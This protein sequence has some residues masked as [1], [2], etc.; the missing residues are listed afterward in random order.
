MSAPAD[1][2]AD[3]DGV[4][5]TAGKA[6]A[7]VH[8]PS[9]SATCSAVRVCE[10]LGALTVAELLVNVWP[11]LVPSQ[12]VAKRTV[13]HGLVCVASHPEAA[14]SWRE[15]VPAGERVVLRPLGAQTVVSV[16]DAAALGAVPVLWESDAWLCV[17]KP[18]GMPPRTGRR[19]LANVVRGMQSLRR[20]ARG[21]SAHESRRRAADGGGPE[22]PWTV[23][24]DG[25]PR[26]GGAWLVAKSV[27]AA[28]DLL[29]GGA[30]PELRWRCLLRG[31]PTAC[32]L[33]GLTSAAASAEGGGGGSC[34]PGGAGVRRHVGSEGLDGGGEGGGSAS[35]VGPG[36]CALRLRVLRTVKSIRFGAI[37]EVSFTLPPAS[38]ALRS[39]LWP[40]AAADA[41]HGVVGGGGRRRQSA[42]DGPRT[43]CVWVEAV[44]VTLDKEGVCGSGS[45]LTRRRWSS[46]LASSSATPMPATAVQTTARG[47]K[48]TL[49]SSAR[50]RAWRKR[51][52]AREKRYTTD[53]DESMISGTR[54][55]HHCHHICN[56][57]CTH[58]AR[59]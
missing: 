6:V 18:A 36:D 35:R 27:R 2:V 39:S 26:V 50:H 3:A 11:A 9:T 1:A 20:L 8:A 57:I 48:A 51:Q 15:R 14:L 49:L 33:T 25:D 29:D 23:A 30:R 52:R 59:R 46:E 45:S 19:S 4:P 41:G 5:T 22:T 28:L 16:E 34:G 24:Y 31:V 58:F 42:A 47:A 10:Q 32:A 56:S 21:E 38:A 12:S 43:E 40:S 17:L 37:S 54:V 44:T 53:L 7:G 13:R 55:F